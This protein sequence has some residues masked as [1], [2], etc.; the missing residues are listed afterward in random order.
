[1]LWTNGTGLSEIGHEK[2]KQYQIKEAISDYRQALALDSKNLI[3]Y[4]YLGEAEAWRMA[5]DSAIFFHTKAIGMSHN[6]G[7][8]DRGRTFYYK[9][10]YEKALN[11]FDQLIA[12]EK[13]FFLSVLRYGP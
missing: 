9:G 13:K 5:Y 6:P 11:D 1:M 4:Y 12:K 2:Y 7:Y 3:A 8:F 10:D